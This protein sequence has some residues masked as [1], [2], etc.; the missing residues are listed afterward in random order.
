M[1]LGYDSAFG[2]DDI[3]TTAQVVC[4][5]ADG[6]PTF[7]WPPSAWARFPSSRLVQISTRASIT[8]K[9]VAVLDVEAGDASPSDG[10]QWA[11]VQR[12]LGQVP[13]VYC[14]ASNWQAVINAFNTANVAQ[15]EYWIAA[16]PGAG[17]TL[18]SLDGIVA[19]GHQYADPSTS[20]GNFD[21]SVFADYWPGVDPV[22][23]GVEM[24]NVSVPLVVDQVDGHAWWVGSVGSN[25]AYFT[26]GW[27]SMT[28]LYDSQDE[29]PLDVNVNFL[30]DD[31]T[32]LAG[33]GA[34]VVWWNKR[35]PVVQIPS[36]TGI[37]TVDWTPVV[38]IVFAGSVELQS[39]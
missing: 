38:G 30:G 26:A 39:S 24:A 28:A 9:G 34:Q 32:V 27:L 14:S 8:G 33:S 22:E 7:A 16:Y 20:G 29:S 6:D 15:P 2:Y 17:P 1:R 21:L 12:G 37:I 3:P 23:N 11:T 18:P 25:S 5:Y 35:G 13:T 31:G 19:V 10:P 4:G 36:G